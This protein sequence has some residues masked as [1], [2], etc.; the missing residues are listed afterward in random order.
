MLLINVKFAESP[1]VDQVAIP[2]VHHV[3]YRIELARETPPDRSVKH[4]NVL[5]P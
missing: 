3:I 2:N 5:L 4:V 1:D